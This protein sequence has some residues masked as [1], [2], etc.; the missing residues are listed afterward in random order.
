MT[1]NGEAGEAERRITTGGRRHAGTIR[2][3]TG[4]P[5][6]WVAVLAASDARMRALAG[7]TVACVAAWSIVYAIWVRRGHEVAATAVDSL[8]LVGLNAATPWIVPADWLQS[9]RSW[10]RPFTTFAAVAY[11]YSTP[12]TVGCA[13]GALVC[14]AGGVFTNAAQPGPAGV[15]DVITAVW[16]LGVVLLAR[17]LWTT[18]LRAARRADSVMRDVEQAR[19][20]AAVDAGVRA[21]ERRLSDELHDSVAST[22][23]VVGIGQAAGPNHVLADR[24]ASDLRKLRELRSPEPGTTETRTIDLRR[25]LDALQP[26]IGLT[27]H[28]QGPTSV[29]L[30]AAV[31]SAL[32][33]AATEALRNV[34][35]HSGVGVATVRLGIGS[36]GVEVV[37]TDSGQG[38]DP[39]QVVPSRRGLTH[40]IH[41][42]MAAVN[43]VASVESV[44]GQGTTVRLEWHDRGD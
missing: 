31:A 2:L 44:P 11:Q 22:L 3:V 12:W 24:A 5:I 7:V 6:A 28:V 42:R 40:S 36:D 32:R 21:A 26:L 10:I 27:V 18:V 25:E 35:R 34:N 37:I 38:F 9:Q 30:P 1:G 41:G 29:V 4:V 20:A 14:V 13:L 17:L 8:V 23:L 19:Q 16:S 43:G 33:D 15:D 39:S